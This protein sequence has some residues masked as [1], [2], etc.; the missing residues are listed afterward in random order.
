MGGRLRRDGTRSLEPPAL[1]GRV[2]VAGVPAGACARRVAPFFSGLRIAITYA[3][4]GAIFAEYVGAKRG[5][6]IFMQLQQNSFRT[7]LV[8]AAVVVTAAIS[9]SL[10]LATYAV[11]R[12]AI[13]WHAAAR[14][15]RASH[16]E[17]RR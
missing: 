15:A 2:E 11:E 5:L 1:H 10:F 16:G 9:V 14:A 7:D 8:M 4:V 12:A 13:P 17:T 3:V 6:G